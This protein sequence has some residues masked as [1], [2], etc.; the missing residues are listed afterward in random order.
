MENFNHV[1]IMIGQM[2]CRSNEQL[3]DCDKLQIVFYFK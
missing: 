2:L 3:S 1:M